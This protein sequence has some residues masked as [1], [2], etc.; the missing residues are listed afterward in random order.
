MRK[1]IGNIFKHFKTVGNSGILIS[2]FMAVKHKYLGQYSNNDIVDELNRMEDEGL[3]ISS[4]NSITLTDNGEASIYGVFNIEFGI[5]DFLSIFKDFKVQKNQ[6]LP[7]QSLLSVKHDK[8][9]PQSNKNLELIIEES[10]SRGYITNV[11]NRSITLTES[12]FNLIY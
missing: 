4:E 7:I 5:K 8:L 1:S 12:G 9:Q 10:I 11:S 6:T 3:I 2:N